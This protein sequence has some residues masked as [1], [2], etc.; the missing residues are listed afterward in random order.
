MQNEYNDNAVMLWGGIK[1]IGIKMLIDKTG[2]S[3]KIPELR[4]PQGKGNNSIDSINI[5]ESI[6]VRIKIGCCR[7]SHTTVVRLN[8]IIRLISGR[9]CAAT[10]TTFWKLS[11]KLTPSLNQGL[12]IDSNS[13]FFR[14]LEFSN[15]TSNVDS[16]FISRYQEQEENKRGYSIEPGRS[17]HH[18]LFGF[19]N[20]INNGSSSDCI[21]FSEKTFFIHKN[22]RVIYLGQATIFAAAIMKFIDDKPI[23]CVM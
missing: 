9:N 10:G 13:W 1:E 21:H 5:I 3:K 23:A 20:D 14:Q 4:L 11:K 12:L 18:P 7:Y 19:V 16:S 8:E 2:I 6:W 22:K 15:Y 17:S